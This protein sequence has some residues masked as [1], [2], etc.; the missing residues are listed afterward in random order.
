MSSFSRHLHVESKAFTP[1]NL[2]HT[3]GLEVY[4]RWLKNIPPD[5]NVLILTGMDPSAIRKFF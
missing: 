5:K 2:A 1:V 3:E 4:T